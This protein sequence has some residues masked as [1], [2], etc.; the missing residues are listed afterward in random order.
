MKL[1][2]SLRLTN[3]LPHPIGYRTE[4]SPKMGHLGDIAESVGW[5]T[6]AR[7]CAPRQNV[8]CPPR[9]L[10]IIPSDPRTIT[11]SRG[12]HA[13]I[14][15]TLDVLRKANPNLEAA[16]VCRSGAEIDSSA[17]S[18]CMLPIPLPHSRFSEP[19]WLRRLGFFGA[20]AAVIMGAD[21]LD[22]H[23]DI[24]WPVQMLRIGDYLARCGTRVSIL[25]FSFNDH[26]DLRMKSVFARLPRNVRINVRD[27]TSARR[28]ERFSTVP[29]SLVADI[30]F[31][32]EAKVPEGGAEL[33]SW[34]EARRAAG[35]CIIGININSSFVGLDAHLREAFV[36]AAAKALQLVAQE[37]RVSWVLIAHDFRPEG[38][39]KILRAL[40]EK[41]R[42]LIPCDVYR[43]PG[44]PSAPELKHIA[45]LMDG[46]V[47]SRAHLA[48]ASLGQSV[49]VAALGYQGKFEGLFD[50]F[51]YP[52]RLLLDGSMVI[53]PPLIR[54]L[55]HGLI[56]DLPKLGAHIRAR[57]PYIQ[58]LARRNLDNVLGIR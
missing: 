21:V 6:A 53:N 24:V 28:F 43:I 54:D 17:K 46:V 14:S 52:R 23:Y 29:Y 16:V 37:R 11:G 5:L 39:N 3:N 32:L 51:G 50:H 47:A 56:E 2:T 36:S 20:D 34:L 8:H 10:V 4:H 48:I 42:Q 26:P 31:L 7:A 30:A 58:E 27:P 15:S 13:T 41:L 1:T 38:D 9:R 45:S 18:L 25:G 49:P 19:R 44:E 22:G 57:L 33:T 55:L 12:D 40:E 35:R